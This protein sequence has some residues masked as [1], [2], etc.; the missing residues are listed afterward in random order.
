MCT[1]SWRWR[2]LKPPAPNV[3]VR[4]CSHFYPTLQF[5]WTSSMNVFELTKIISSVQALLKY[6]HVCPFVTSLQWHYTL[7][8][9]CGDNILLS[10]ASFPSGSLLL[11]GNCADSTE[12][13]QYY[14]FQNKSRNCKWA[15]GDSTKLKQRRNKQNLNQVINDI[16]A[17]CIDN[18][19]EKSRQHHLKFL[20]G[21]GVDQVTK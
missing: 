11:A 14:W 17:N 15:K 6:M 3:L 16:L 8:L 5:R 9:Q 19:M 18:D 13:N 21:G 2:N 4:N 10:F 7:A 20:D 12:W 1:V